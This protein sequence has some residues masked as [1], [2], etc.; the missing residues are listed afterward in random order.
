MRKSY[1]LFLITILLTACQ[2]GYQEEQLHGSWTGVSVT[3]EGTPL[4]VDPSLIQLEFTTGHYYTYKSTLD[5]REAGTYHVEANY[6]YTQDTLNQAST[7]KA[8]ELMQVTDDSL[9]IRMIEEDQ[10]RLL[11]LVKD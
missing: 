5:Y 3:E 9:V 10:E 11:T 2:G 7:E 6:L 8:V 4:A 1:C